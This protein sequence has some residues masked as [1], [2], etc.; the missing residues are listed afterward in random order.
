MFLFVPFVSFLSP[1]LYAMDFFFFY[2]PITSLLVQ[3]NLLFCLR[4]PFHARR[5]IHLAA[6]G[7]HLF[8]L[9]VFVFGGGGG[10]L[11]RHMGEMTH[12]CV[13]MD[14]RL[15]P[16]EDWA[17]TGYWYDIRLWILHIVR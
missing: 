8:L 9:S 6:D 15:L 3:L 2:L 16:L 11:R 10:S 14:V 1:L 12:L 7:F 4:A 17:L 13:C 5:S